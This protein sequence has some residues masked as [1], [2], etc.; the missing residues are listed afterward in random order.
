MNRSSE[1]QLMNRGFILEEDLNN[2][3]D[4]TKDELLELINSRE[5]YK[6]TIAVRLL[7]SLEDEDNSIITLFC[8][9]LTK[10]N[11][12]YTKIAICAALSAKG[13]KAAKVM[14][15]YLGR[16]GTNQHTELPKKNFKKKSYPLPRDII[17]RTLAHIGKEILPELVEVL[18]SSDIFKIREVIDAIGFICFYDYTD[19]PLNEL[20]TCLNEKINDDIIRWK[21][22]RALGSFNGQSVID[23]L[24]NVKKNDGQE[25]IRE[26]AERSLSMIKDRT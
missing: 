20:I 23:I 15:K 12:L 11:K 13:S 21:V 1:I 5:A 25:R 22:V 17:S 2:Y 14:V 4:A 10:E 19:Y 16:I 24:T 9:K 3:M 26:E 8:E 7:T 6:R 18:S